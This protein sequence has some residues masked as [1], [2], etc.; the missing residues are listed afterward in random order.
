LAGILRPK[1][2]R[3]VEDVPEWHGRGMCD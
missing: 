3:R 1:C 2:G